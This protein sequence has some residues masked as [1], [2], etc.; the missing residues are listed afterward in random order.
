MA[1]TG[2]H[3]IRGFSRLGI[4]AAVLVAIGGVVTTGIVAED[5]YSRA[6]RAAFPE[7]KP[8]FGLSDADA[9]LVPNFEPDK[10]YDFYQGGKWWHHDPATGNAPAPADSREPPPGFV[11]DQPSPAA[12]AEAEKASSL[13]LGLTALAALAAFIFLWGL[14]WVIA[15][16]VKD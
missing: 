16:F 14:G 1:S 8:A 9:G 4:G 2:N 15:G 11:I 10:P 12:F 7:V 13:G 3:I 6:Q 5:Q